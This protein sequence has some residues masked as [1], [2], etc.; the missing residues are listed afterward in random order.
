MS[1]EDIVSYAADPQEWW[2]ELQRL[3]DEADAVA[4]ADGVPISPRQEELDMWNE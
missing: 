2:I 1:E 3:R 4:R